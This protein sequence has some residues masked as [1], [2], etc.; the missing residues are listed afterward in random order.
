MNTRDVLWNVTQGPAQAPTVGAQ[1]VDIKD[2][3]AAQAGV[4]NRVVHVL[5]PGEGDDI[6]DALAAKLGVPNVSIW[7]SI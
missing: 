3:E 1:D 5:E 4:P 7:T 2:A 6:K